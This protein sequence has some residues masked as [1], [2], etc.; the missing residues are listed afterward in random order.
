MTRPPPAGFEL[1]VVRHGLTDWNAD[2]KIQG[3]TDIPLN[4][5]GI[6]QAESLAAQISRFRFDLVLSSDLIRAFQT[7]QI[8]TRQSG[9]PVITDRRLREINM[10]Q[11]EGQR[12]EDIIRLH[13]PHAYAKN[14]EE[15]RGFDGESLRDVAN[16]LKSIFAEY[17]QRLPGGKILIVTHGLTA[18]ILHC[19]VNGIDLLEAYSHV[20]ENC[21]IR[22]YL[23]PGKST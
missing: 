9:M 10:G 13:A 4:K 18:G 22:R 15:K 5:Q 20:P 8:L 16:R 19:M 6:E 12:W 21:V 2:R 14:A 1:Y 7:A 23:W 11:F 3:H 17:E